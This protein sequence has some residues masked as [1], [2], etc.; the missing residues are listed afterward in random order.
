[1]T[2]HGCGPAQPIAFAAPMIGEEEIAEVVDTLRSNWITTGPKTQQ[3][4][5]EFA[6][7]LG[8]PGA[9][10]V[11]SC[12]AALHLA[13]L[14][15]GAGAGDAVLTSTMTFCS[16]VHVIEHTGATPVLC[17]VEPDT[18][19][20]DPASVERQL[21]A[22][23]ARGLRPKIL[24]PVHFAGHPCA[25]DEL[26]DIAAREALDVVEDAAHALPAAYKGRPVG[27]TEGDVRRA[28]A[29]SFYAT[30]NLTT[31]EGG[32]LTGSEGLLDEARIWSL[33]GMSKDA[34]K[35][36]GGAGAWF[37]EVTRAGFKYNLTDI[38]AAIGIHQLRKVDAFQRRRE[39]I[40]RRYL[41]GFGT[42]PGLEMPAERREVAHA[43][44]LFVLRISRELS[45]DRNDVIER[46]AAA[47]IAA[48]VHFIPVHL[49]PYYRER[50][51][52]APTDFPVALDAFER[53]LSLPVHLQMTDADVD[54][55]VD[56]VRQI[57]ASN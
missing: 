45:V 8:V 38:A 3:F 51:D 16:T 7:R 10:A 20:L 33:H 25:M 17:D 22:C 52:Y 40:V 12:T 5:D 47:G 9:L 46:L 1:M 26:L 30:K 42:V 34:W 11:N 56:V 15:M 35:R 18:L 19:N 57:V 6:A 50:Y 13:L 37:Y 41:T 32:M 55:V 24:L 29:F 23:H 49:H 2:E 39:E 21:A 14:A 54:R 44:H 53:S 36:Y 27:T 31:G 28:V 48:S 4:A 43:W